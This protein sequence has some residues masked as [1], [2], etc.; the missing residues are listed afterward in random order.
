M[1]P[2][3][4]VNYEFSVR[5]EEMKSNLH[6]K[7]LKMIVAKKNSGRIKFCCIC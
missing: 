3:Y 4:D 2:S 5:V 1:R 7:L 6:G